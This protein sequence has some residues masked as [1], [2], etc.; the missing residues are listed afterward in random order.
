MQTR[1]LYT[2]LNSPRLVDSPL[3][4]PSSTCSD[5]KSETTW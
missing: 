3:V 1:Y 5:V 2:Y 4:N